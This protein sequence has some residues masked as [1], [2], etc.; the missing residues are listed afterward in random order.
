ML[1]LAMH[2]Q[3]WCLLGLSVSADRQTDRRRQT[4]NPKMGLVGLAT[5][6]AGL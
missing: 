4:R 1:H 3:P 2:R 6:L 5:R